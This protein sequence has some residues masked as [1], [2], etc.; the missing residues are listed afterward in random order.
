MELALS[1]AQLSPSLSICSIMF[2]LSRVQESLFRAS[3]QLGSCLWLHFV[4]IFC[5]PPLI[6]T[7][8]KNFVTI[9]CTNL[10][11]TTFVHNFCSQHLFSTLVHNFCSR[12]LFTAFI[13]NICSQLLL[14]SFVHNIVDSLQSQLL[15]TTLVKTRLT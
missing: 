10:L 13:K 12:P 4:H 2:Q 8:L 1:L 3:S 15:F 9:F 14:K 7:L 5:S 11:F 6:K